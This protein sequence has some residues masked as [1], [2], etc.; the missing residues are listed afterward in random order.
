MDVMRAYNGHG[1]LY[2]RCKSSRRL[3]SMTLGHDW[4]WLSFDFGSEIAAYHGHRRQHKHPNGH[5]YAWAVYVF[6]TPSLKL[7]WPHVGEENF[8]AEKESLLPICKAIS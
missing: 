8:L 4:S 3:S 7:V 6:S 2:P 5:L 1:I